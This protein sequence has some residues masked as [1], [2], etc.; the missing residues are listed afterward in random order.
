MKNRTL[1]ALAVAII[2]ATLLG[3]S[4]LEYLAIK[5]TG[6]VA[7]GMTFAEFE[8]QMPKEERL[9]FWNYSFYP[10]DYEYPVLAR[11]E[12]DEIV[13][14]QVIDISSIRANQETFEKLTVGMTL[15][16]VTRMVGVP[17]GIAKADDHV[18]VYAADSELLYQIRYVL[19][20]GVMYVES[21]TTLNVEQSS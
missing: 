11:C 8:A 14:L 2:A 4:I 13:Q 21:I 15:S 9:D 1:V 10:N 19:T 18:L 5:D 7:V 12:E 20:D 16:Q 3:N 6:G 17:G